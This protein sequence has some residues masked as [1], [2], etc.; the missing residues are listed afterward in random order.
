MKRALSTLAIVLLFLS[1]TSYT[2]AEEMSPEKSADIERLLEITGA[3]DI[4]KQMSGVFVTQMSDAVAARRP[5][6]PPK[7]FDV[8]KEEIN[9]LI[10]ENFPV[11]VALITPIY[12]KHFT[13]DEIKGL[14]AFYQTELGRKTIQVMPALMQEGMSVGQQWG[15]ALVP[16]IQKRVLERLK[17]EGVDLSA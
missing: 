11:F 6:L 13:H 17:A 1:A 9:K 8:I 2:A 15:Q 16:E 10:D 7:L 14:L 5:D 12:D 3:L 4:G